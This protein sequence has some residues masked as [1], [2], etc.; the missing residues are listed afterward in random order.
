V[1][2]AV[3]A[4]R[5]P[6]LELLAESVRRPSV[7]GTE[8][9][10]T[11]FYRAW[12]AD[13]GWSVHRQPLAGSRVVGAE[14]PRATERAN[15]LVRPRAAAG[16]EGG[17]P[18]LVL[19]GHVDVVPPGDEARWSVPPFG[20]L[21]RDGRVYGRGAVDTKGGVAAA[22]FACAALEEAGI[23][24]GYD[25]VLALVVGEETTGIGTQASF[26][27][28][29]EPAAAIVLEPTGNDVVPVC[30]GLLF[31]T[32][33]TFGRSAHTSAPWLGEDAL[34]RLLEIH[35][36]LADLAETRNAG[37]AHPLLDGVPSAIPYVVGTLRAGTF[38]A[39]V[40]DHAT[41]SGRIGI[42]PGEPV[43]HVKGL[44][45]DL[46]ARSPGGTAR[47]PVVR[48]DNAGLAGWATPLD[49]PLVAAIGRARSEVLG[50]PAL[51]GMTSGSDAAWYGARG[52]PT[53]LFGPGD[54]PAAHG[55]D[56]AVPED[57]VLAAATVLALTLL[58]LD[59]TLGAR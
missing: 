39:A 36:A 41:M 55:P 56:E 24:L 34:S 14:E 5:E 45:E 2:G 47:P 48:W 7:S 27:L 25:V 6:L 44:V 42:A 53:V 33:E 21:R 30:S 31:F 4:G 37:Y 58:D 26:D 32:I 29:P 15:L 49:D 11:E 54:L 38:R 40:P 43:E 3:A 28:L 23:R 20:G 35:H 10:A 22:L 12:C 1:A 17:C 50:R 57:A 16:G 13:R 52:V 9:A 19:N 46:V 8:D 18:T 51:R 59:D